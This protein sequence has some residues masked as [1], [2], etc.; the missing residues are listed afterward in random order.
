MSAPFRRV[1]NRCYRWAL[2]VAVI[3]CQLL[4]FSDAAWAQKKRQK[5]APPPPEKS[6]VLPYAI[7]VMGVALGLIVVCRPVKR[8][9]EP[10]REDPRE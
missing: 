1:L 8:A 10:R 6:Y 2:L 7:V 3:A 9:D 5:E 4:T